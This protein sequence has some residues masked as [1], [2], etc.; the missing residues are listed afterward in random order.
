M[1]KIITLT[2]SP[3]IDK[4][5]SVS[6]LEPEKK[7]RCSAPRF[8]PGGGGIN[9]ARVIKRLGGNVSAVYPY[10]GHTGKFFN[11]L[12]KKENIIST[13]VASESETR[14]NLTVVNV[15]DNDQYRFIMPCPMLPEK[16]W[17]ACLKAVEKEKEASYIIVSGSMPPGTMIDTIFSRLSAFAITIN[18]KLVVDTSGQALGVAIR[19]GVYLIKPNIGELASLCGRKWI[20]TS[21]IAPLAKNIIRNNKCRVVV[22]SLGKNGAMLV[23]ENETFMVKAPEVNRISSVGAGDSMLGGIV[24]SISRGKNL[25]QAVAYGVACGTAAT[26]NPGTELCKK[27]DAAFLYAQMIAEKITV[28]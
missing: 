16:E 23:T 8:E 4:S 2:L 24:Y 5:T 14:E 6:S 1:S 28:H 3:C 21:D 7:L 27:K 11:E 17:D 26:L 22:V 12:I 10:G 18:A 19:E 13:A 20:E 25:K 9:V 15:S